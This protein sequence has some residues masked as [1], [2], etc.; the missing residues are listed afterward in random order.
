M[1]V[2]THQLNDTPTGAM[3]VLRQKKGVGPIPGN[4]HPFPEIIGI[5]RII[6]QHISL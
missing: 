6:L 3:T 1:L 2:V 5:I 4:P